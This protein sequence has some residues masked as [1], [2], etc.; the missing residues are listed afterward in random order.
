MWEVV[1]EINRVVLIAVMKFLFV[2]IERG[3]HVYFGD[4]SNLMY[5][6]DG[7]FSSIGRCQATLL[8][9]LMCDAYFALT[10]LTS[11]IYY[12]II[13]LKLASWGSL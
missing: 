6:F 1:S 13:K 3:A 11:S 8:R 10:H 7:C 12:Y 9:H 2:L 4:L 5:L